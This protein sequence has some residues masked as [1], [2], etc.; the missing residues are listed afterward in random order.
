[1]IPQCQ[2]LLATTAAD[3]AQIGG[4]LDNESTAI[5]RC[6]YRDRTLVLLLEASAE[7]LLSVSFD[8]A[9]GGGNGHA[10]EH[11]T[12]SDLILIKK[13]CTRSGVAL[14]RPGSRPCQTIDGCLIPACISGRD[15]L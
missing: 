13:S 5:N 4:V 6:G 9:V 12:D 15:C 1:M 7:S 8:G 11:K 10:G 3:R 14:A 2:E